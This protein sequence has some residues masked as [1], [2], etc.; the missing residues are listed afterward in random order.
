MT[1]CKCKTRRGCT[2]LKQRRSSR[3]S[4]KLC[5]ARIMKPRRFK[6]LRKRQKNMHKMYHKFKLQSTSVRISKSLNNRKTLKVNFIAKAHMILMV[7]HCNTQT[8]YQTW[9]SD[10]KTNTKPQWW[11]RIL[12]KLLRS[13]R[14]SSKSEMVKTMTLLW[15]ITGRSRW[16]SL[17]LM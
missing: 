10:T 8:S 4:K 5:T 12:P 14:R 3:P 7:P 16:T 2:H 13:L 1:F 15:L 9:T 6:T 11:K 17:K